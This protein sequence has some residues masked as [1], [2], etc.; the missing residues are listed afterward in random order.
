MESTKGRKSKVRIQSYIS[1]NLKEMME[2]YSIKNG[3]TVSEITNIALQQFFK[4]KVAEDNLDFIVSII[5]N[6]IHKELDSKL[7]RLLTLVAKST[8]SSLSSQYLQV[9]LLSY[10]FRVTDDKEFLQEKL[11]LADELRI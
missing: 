11:K 5:E 9:Y 4:M 7:K 6:T 1:P 10:I 2:K 8:K 3:I